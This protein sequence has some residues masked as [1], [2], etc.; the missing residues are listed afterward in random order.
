MTAQPAGKA[1]RRYDKHGLTKMKRSLQVL[2]RRAIDGRTV[3]GKALAAW[4]VELV[5]DLGGAD[6]IS[7]QRAALIELAVR[8]KLMLDSVD[9]WLLSQPSLV[10]GRKKSLLP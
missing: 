5:S 8:N 9:A 1:K 6:S 2:G 4:R 7:T 3:T 10:N